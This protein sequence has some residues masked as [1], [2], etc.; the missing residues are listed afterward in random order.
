MSLDE[1]VTALEQ[2][3]REFQREFL[4]HLSE[5]NRHMATLNK[6]IT[7][8]EINSRDVD[9]NLGM[10]L[11]MVTGQGQDIR[12]IRSDLGSMGERLERVES[13]LD[14]VGSRL[15]G[16]DKRFDGV[17][18]RFDSMDQ[19]FDRMLQLLVA[20]ASKLGTE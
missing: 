17:D 9:H 1:R 18:E 19:K 16:M 2:G 14:S 20:I 13:R 8:Q 12:A 15:D 6:V 10:L 7:Q 4:V 11:G 3:S 5:N